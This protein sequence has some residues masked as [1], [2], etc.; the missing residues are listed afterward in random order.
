[1]I[2]KINAPVGIY[3][4]GAR[5]KQE[6]ALF[7]SLG[8]LPQEQQ[9]V[10]VCDGIGGHDYGEIASSVVSRAVGAW[11]RDYVS[12][13]S[14][15]TYERA[16]EAVAFAQEQLNVASREHPSDKPMGTTLAMLVIGRNG[17]VAAHIGDSRIYHVRP[18]SGT[19]LYR[20]RDHSLVNDLFLK[21]VLSRRETELSTKR[22]IL[23]RA[24]LP[25]PQPAQTPDVAMITNVE[26]GDYFLVC[27]DGVCGEITDEQLLEVLMRNNS[28][29]QMK[30]A[31]IQM[32]AKNGSD[33]RT[34]VL[35]QVDSVHHEEGETLLIDNEAAMCDKMVNYEQI[36]PDIAPSVVASP[37]AKDQGES[38]ATPPI[39]PIPGEVSAQ[40]GEPLV[41]DGEQ[42]SEKF[43][44]KNK[45]KSVKWAGLIILTSLLLAGGI[46]A[47]FF[48]GSSKDKSTKQVVATDTLADP[49]V[50]I[51]SL[52]PVMPGDSMQVGTDVSVP[53]APGIGNVE[54]PN[55]GNS[56]S[57]GGNDSK[58]SLD[59]RYPTG[60]SVSV[61][62]SPR[63][64]GGNVP[65][66][67][68]Y[69]NTENFGSD[70]PIHDDEPEAD[71]RS[72][73]SSR[74]Q[75]T[76]QPQANT[77]TPPPPP[78]RPRASD[79]PAKSNRNVAVPLPSRRDKPIET[80]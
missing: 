27:S 43:A 15:M 5:A 13:D 67:D 33:N 71:D 60:S 45:Y 1:M 19:I 6:D 40:E 35:F 29:D 46:A 65:P 51:D 77:S 58:A 50:S 41:V 24:M 34:A 70:E 2:I 56:G 54:L 73:V 12:D 23:T 61:P 32:L 57:T 39:P 48:G 10:V 49:D 16:L 66:Y 62:R 76:P 59:G 74:R 21:G 63:Y 47:C 9:V 52:L 36:T 44:I 31:A 30:L 17:V 26:P 14:P 25:S 55:T 53:R 3:E 20:S 7:P 38:A 72:S 78:S 11:V 68:P 28:G 75:N 37:L 79:D 18:S 42:N 22:S 8:E 69:E 80:P 4:I 64:N